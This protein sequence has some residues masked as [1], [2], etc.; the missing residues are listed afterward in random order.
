MDYS[1]PEV[2]NSSSVIVS[3]K[4]YSWSWGEREEVFHQ[5]KATVLA[6]NSKG[7]IIDVVSAGHVTLT[8]RLFI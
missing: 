8:F 3:E 4:R 6:P 5:A 2:Q 1:E 7:N